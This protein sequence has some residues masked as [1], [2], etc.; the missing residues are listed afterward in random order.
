MANHKNV[1]FVVQLIKSEEWVTGDAFYPQLTEHLNKANRSATRSDAKAYVKTAAKRLK[2]KP[3][4]F[5]ILQATE[6]RDEQ[7]NLVGMTLGVA[8]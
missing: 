3:D 5:K 1:V 8:E 2:K 6:E 7:F 4:E